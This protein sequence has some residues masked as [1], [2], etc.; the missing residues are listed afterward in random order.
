MRSC[1]SVRHLLKVVYLTVVYHDFVGLGHTEHINGESRLG[2]HCTK[3]FS[4]R[5][6]LMLQMN[7]ILSS[8]MR[9]DIKKKFIG[10]S[11][12]HRVSTWYKIDSF[13][14]KYSFNILETSVGP[15]MGSWYLT[16]SWGLIIIVKLSQWSHLNKNEVLNHSDCIC[17][18]VAVQT[19]KQ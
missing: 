4:Y 7:L 17:Y 3:S 10:H 8:S 13:W 2:L 9:P 16:Q 18:S 15:T 5:F 19:W 14:V 12:L 6:L 11:R 1:S